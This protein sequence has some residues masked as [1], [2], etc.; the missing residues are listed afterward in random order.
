LTLGCA[1]PYPLTMSRAVLLVLCYL[2]APMLHADDIGLIRVGEKWRYFKGVQE[3]PAAWTRLDFNDANWPESMAGF[4]TPGSFGEATL[5]SDYG[6]T[7]QALYFRKRFHV[8]DISRIKELLLRLDYDDGVVIYLNGEELARRGLPGPPGSPVPFTASATPHARGLTEEIVLTGGLSALRQGENVLAV[9]LVGSGQGDSLFAVVPEL[10][11]N[12]S[13]TPYIQNTT[14]NSTQIAW[15]S[16][17]PVVALI[18][19]GVETAATRRMELGPPGTNHVATLEGLEPD[20]LYRYR[21]GS[22]VA[23]GDLWS[24]WSTFRTFKLS[25]PLSFL[26]IGDSGWASPQQYLVANQMRRAEADLI[27]HTGDLCYPGINH[28]N[29]DLRLLS[30]YAPQMR[31][32]PMFWVP[33]NHDAYENLQVPIDIFFHP[34][35]NVTGSEL[36]YSFDHGDAHFAVMWTDMLPGSRYHPG[37][38]QYE[39]LERD[40]A[41]SKKPWKFVLMHHCWRTSAIHITDDYDFNGIRD[42]IQLDAIAELASRHGVQA[43]IN[44]HDH[45]F[46]RFTPSRGVHSFTSGGGGAA[47]YGFYSKHPDT[48]Q[49]YPRYHYM[50]AT[51]SGDIATFEAVDEQGQKFDSSQIS[52]AFPAKREYRSL[53]HTPTIETAPAN[54]SDGNIAGQTFGF[55]GEPVHG[56]PGSSSSAG[57]LFVQNDAENL[58][59]GF[60][61]LLL[62]D[63]DELYAFIETPTLP[64]ENLEP[65]GWDLPFTNFAPNLVLVAGHE[66]ADI[67]AAPQPEGVRQGLMHLRAGLPFVPEF[68]MQQFNRSP[69]TGIA[70]HEY[71]ANFVELAVP[72]ASLQLRPTNSIRI[73]AVTRLNQPNRPFDTGGIVTSNYEPIELRLAAETIFRLSA[74]VVNPGSLGIS[75]QAIPGTTY[76]LE[77][78]DR[79]GNAFVGVYS[80]TASSDRE[81]FTVPMSSQQQFFRVRLVAD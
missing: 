24:D 57:R 80:T 40:L 35:N 14:P 67:P 36:F 18:E 65:F 9:Q 23:G 74:T 48:V 68:R 32:I 56:K 62:H 10:L 6:S 19:F 46:E 61:N 2:A 51:I 33:G 31:T 58:Y 13:R 38:P 21:I 54:D 37:S 78:L 8:P 45:C 55:P 42:H 66:F 63:G 12:F 20:T 3:P 29:A 4:S 26:V 17:T 53:W 73:A 41:G 11:A 43:L 79:A 81:E 75:W 60:D 70:L 22:R 52:R 72:L 15:K 5:L 39:W 71:A 16:I 50:K 7:Y 76:R 34:T 77:R 27:L 64:P 59:L 28:G 47:L 30:V 1:A 49:F 25:G 69:Q 44:G